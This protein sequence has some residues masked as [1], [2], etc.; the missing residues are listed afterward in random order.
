MRRA[1]RMHMDSLWQAPQYRTAL[2][3]GWDASQAVVNLIRRGVTFEQAQPPFSDLLADVLGDPDRHRA[4]PTDLIVGQP[5]GH[6]P[7]VIAFAG[8]SGRTCLFGRTDRDD[9][10]AP[11]VRVSLGQ[12]ATLSIAMNNGQLVRH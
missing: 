9:A 8:S 12:R 6:R 4:R 11:R 7:L 2:A 3:F 5:T 10:G 1:E